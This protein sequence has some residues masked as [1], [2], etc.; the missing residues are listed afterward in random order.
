MFL[1][2]STVFLVS[3]ELFSL[4]EVVNLSFLSVVVLGFTV[5][6]SN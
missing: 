5:F 2:Y 3:L 4:L 1:E 6:F